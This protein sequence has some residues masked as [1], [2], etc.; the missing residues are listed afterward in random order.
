MHNDSLTYDM[1]VDLIESAR[2]L[3]NEPLSDDT[4]KLRSQIT[5]IEPLLHKLLLQLA[6]VDAVLSIEQARQLRP[7]MKGVTDL[8]RRTEVKANTAHTERDVKVLDGLVRA[9]EKRLEIALILIG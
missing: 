4:A 1:P 2:S 7:S 8:D 9:V 5:Q 3:L 6:D